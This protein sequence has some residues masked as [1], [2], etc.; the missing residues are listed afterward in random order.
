MDQALSW[1]VENVKL[2]D[3]GIFEWA[4][5]NPD[6]SI[7]LGKDATTFPE[8]R[9]IAEK[10]Y[11][12]KCLEPQKF[13]QYSQKPNSVLFDIRDF[14]ERRNFTIKLPN[15]KHYPVDRLIRLISSGSRKVKGK[16]IYIFD[17]CGTQS[18]WLQY[19]LA[20]TGVGQYFYLKGGVLNW[21][22]EGFDQFGRPIAK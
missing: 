2:Y 6:L 17:N 19:F 5:A 1:G 9:Y 21:Q 12:K 8:K 10:E 15:I 3:T 16:K 11:A 22:A 14:G 7:Y 18:K 20:E 4:N 13:I